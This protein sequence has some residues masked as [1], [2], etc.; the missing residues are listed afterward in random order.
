MNKWIGVRVCGWLGSV[1]SLASLAGF[2]SWRSEAHNLTVLA[3][4]VAFEA[5]ACLFWFLWFAGSLLTWASRRQFDEARKVEP[6]PA[7]ANLAPVCAVCGQRAGMLVCS[8]HAMTVCFECVPRHNEAG[9]AYHVARRAAR[10]Q[11][12]PIA[13]ASRG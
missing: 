4:A 5:G 1:A 12:A 13:G 11:G 6:S 3:V 8:T 7:I 9:C 2:A 10:S